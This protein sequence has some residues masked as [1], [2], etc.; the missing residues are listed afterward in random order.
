MYIFLDNLKYPDL[1]LITEHWLKDHE[2]V[3]IPDYTILS[4]F[5]R[6]R[7][8]HG[9]SMILV[10]RDFLK[11]NKFQAVDNF[12]NLLLEN[13]FE[14]SIVFSED[15]NIYIVCIY[16]SPSSDVS[17]F[18]RGLDALLSSISISSSIIVSGDF[19]INFEDLNSIST[20][21]L[22]NL[23]ESHNLQMHVRSPTRVSQH[24]STLIDYVCSNFNFYT[25]D[26][27]VIEAGLSDHSAV[28]CKFLK[29]PRKCKH[30]FKYGRIF[31]R[32]NYEKFYQL[33]VTT[34]WNVVLV[35][36]DPIQAFHKTLLSKYI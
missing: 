32:S 2:L 13:V 15:H 25:V 9:G 35:S 30:K 5:C 36:Q 11:C 33:C 3:Y 6:T 1:V 22:N 12:N 20:I 26:C 24:S 16:R 7:S 29:C 18:F 27:S 34:S 10:N 19:N 17:E 4:I 21:R 28:V 31:S 8:T 14:F 23:L